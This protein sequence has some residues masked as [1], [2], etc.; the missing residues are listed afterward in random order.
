[1]EK[2]RLADT[3][4]HFV[5]LYGLR[6]IAAI[7]VLIFHIFEIHGFQD[8]IYIIGHGYL[9]VDFFF[10]LSGFVIGYAYDDRW[11]KMSFFSFIKRRII[12]LQPMV[13][14]GTI[15]GGILFYFGFSSVFPLIGETPVW[16]MLL[17]LLL[18]MLLIPVPPSMD[19][20]GWKEM[21]T[22]DAP[23]WSPFFE[24]IANILYGLFIRKFTKTALF[25]L[26]FLSGLATLYLSLTQGNVNGGWEF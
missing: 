6:G 9:A 7:M 4:P 24:Y 19:I 23:C 25:I 10:V 5:I 20:R 8:S 12:R 17:Y 18:G 3:K 21:Y 11:T 14:L 2:I 22:L 26:V 13:I 15:L 16:K 1:M